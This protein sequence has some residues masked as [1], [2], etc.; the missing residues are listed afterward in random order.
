M[1][2]LEITAP[3]G[4]V[5]VPEIAPFP[6]NWA[7]AVDGARTASTRRT[8][9]V[10]AAKLRNDRTDPDLARDDSHVCVRAD[11][12]ILHCLQKRKIWVLPC[13]FQENADSK[14]RHEWSDHRIA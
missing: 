14:F 12:L 13:H 6:A 9:P 3:V 2:A 1:V 10:A 5:T 7:F 4:S 8:R 11:C